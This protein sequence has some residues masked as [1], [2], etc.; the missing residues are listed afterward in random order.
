MTLAWPIA[1]YRHFP[2]VL[3]NWKFDYLGRMSGSYSEINQPPWYYLTALAMN[4][5]P[6]TL[7]AIFGMW[8][9]WPRVRRERISPERV[10]WCWAIVPMLIF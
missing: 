3:D 1:A 5:A 6:W 10:L 7:L 8:L 9:S 2:D 4:L